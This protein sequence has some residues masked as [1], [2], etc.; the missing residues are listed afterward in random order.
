MQGSHLP[1]SGRYRRNNG[2]WRNAAHDVLSPASLKAPHT[3]TVDDNSADTLR[4]DT[5]VQTEGAGSRTRC[6]A[7]M[8]ANPGGFHRHS[9]T[10]SAGGRFQLVTGSTDSDTDP[11]LSPDGR[12]LA[13]ASARAGGR[14]CTTSGLPRLT[15]RTR[16]NSPEVQERTRGRRPG[17]PTGG[18]CVFDSRREDFRIHL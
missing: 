1:L 12:R 17:R 3:P 11:E 6:S 8:F 15:D 7:D 2:D 13:F 10:L 9:L 14:R 5:G 4:S 16:S 18:G